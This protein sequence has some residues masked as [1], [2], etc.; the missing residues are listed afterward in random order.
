MMDLLLGWSCA[1]APYGPAA[2][3][4]AA[5]CRCTVFQT[6]VLHTPVL[7]TPV[8]QTP[9]LQA[10]AHGMSWRVAG[11]PETRRRRSAVLT[12]GR[13][14]PRL[15]GIRAALF[16]ARPPLAAKPAAATTSAALSRAAPP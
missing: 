10:V 2:F 12:D 4:C 11:L 15:N 1:D 14:A 9:V 6:P 7:H 16:A 13:P 3:G 8:L 5:A